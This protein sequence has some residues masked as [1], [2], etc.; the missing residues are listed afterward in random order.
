V[1]SLYDSDT[2]HLWTIAGFSEYILAS[3]DITFSNQYW[4]Q[5]VHGLEATYPYVD[6]ATGLFNGTKTLDW[7]RIGQGGQNT[8]LNALYHHTLNL[9]AR[10]SRLISTS[11]KISAEKWLSLAVKTK[12]SMNQ[13]LYDPSAG[14]LYDNTTA[15]GHQI[16]PQDGNSAAIN[17]DITN[18]SRQA[19][20]IAQNLSKRLTQFGASAPE[21]PGTI[22]PFIG[23]QE[24]RVQFAASPSGSTRALALMR[25]QWGHMRQAFSNP[26]FI[27]GYGSNGE[28]TYGFYP[29][30]AGKSLISHAHGWST[31]PVF[32]LLNN[33]VG[34]QASPISVAP[35]DG[36]WAFHPAVIGSGLTYADGGYSTKDGTFSASWQFHGD[37]FSATLTAPHGLTKT[38]YIPT[39]S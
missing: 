26:T 14:L 25:T 16:Y 27:E 2:Y 21:L 5:I 7:E 22:S 12:V 37:V 20:S 38:I 30:Y 19:L 15:A 11:D 33:M 4:A 32:S 13:L 28:L 34:I 29:G 1:I 35:A 18:S 36:S 9:A 31:G 17:F 10:V 3:G 8:V 6:L 39:I 24:L 23:S